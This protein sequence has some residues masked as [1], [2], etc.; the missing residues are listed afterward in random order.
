M[1]KRRIFTTLSHLRESV[2]LTGYRTLA[3]DLDPS[4]IFARG[5]SV[6]SLIL[7]GLDNL[8][9]WSVVLE[10]LGYL[11]IFGLMSDK[12]FD[13]DLYVRYEKSNTQSQLLCKS[14][15]SNS[16]GA[17]F[18]YCLT[19]LH[20]C[21]TLGLHTLF[22]SLS[23]CWTQRIRIRIRNFN[24]YKEAKFDLWDQSIYVFLICVSFLRRIIHTLKHKVSMCE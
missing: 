24:V 13:Y 1:N 15:A 19:Q 7:W 4:L 8:R 17:K 18:A 14:N 11:S 3:G 10:T 16:I 12:V 20:L 9:T 23:R 5:L 2:T 22:Y 21:G 6:D